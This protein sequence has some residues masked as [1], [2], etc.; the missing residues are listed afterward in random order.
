MDEISL[1]VLSYLAE[2]PEATDTPEGIAT[3]WLLE[4]EIRDQSAAV[5]QALARLVI[6]GWL[7]AAQAA[8]SGV[9]YRLNPARAAAVRS[10]LGGG[11]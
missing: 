2:N 11:S 5:E 10:L 7:V 6:D 3:W 8:G 9:R 4:R 1:R